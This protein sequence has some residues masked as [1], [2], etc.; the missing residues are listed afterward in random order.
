M[1]GKKMGNKKG[2]QFNNMEVVTN[3]KEH[4]VA[5][6]KMYE[7]MGSLFKLEAKALTHPV[8]TTTMLPETH[9]RILEQ[10]YEIGEEMKNLG[11]YLDLMGGK[12][13]LKPEGDPRKSQVEIE[14]DK[15]GQTK[16]GGNEKI[17][18]SNIQPSKTTSEETKEGEE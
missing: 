4:F 10:Y 13:V 17:F 9:K 11:T 6:C 2:M 7:H 1:K 16:E 12:K 14:M 18:V 5:L 8:F 3:A 15:K